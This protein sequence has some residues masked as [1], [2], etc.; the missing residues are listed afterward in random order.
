MG[1]ANAAIATLISRLTK[2]LTLVYTFM[3]RF[4]KIG[5]RLT[6][7]FDVFFDVF[8]FKKVITV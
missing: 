3:M 6:R 8:R 7:N 1:P 2:V 5:I 4:P